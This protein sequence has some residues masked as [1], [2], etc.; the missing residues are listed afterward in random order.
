[1]IAR[2][3][4]CATLAAALLFPGSGAAQGGD[5]RI[6][7]EISAPAAY[8]L[9]DG[10]LGGFGIEIVRAIQKEIGDHTPI[11]VVPWARGYK[12]LTQMPGVALMPTARTA[13]RENL[14][15]W[16]G[17]LMSINWTFYGL[18]GHRFDVKSLDDAR[19]VDGIG[20]YREDV[21]AKFLEEQGFTNLQVVDSQSVNLRKLLRQRIELLV[22]SDVGMRGYMDEDKTLRGKIKPV[23]SFKR[24]DLYLAF[25]KGTDPK[26]L[27]KWSRAYNK[28]LRNGTVEKI[29][30]RW[31]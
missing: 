15:E 8:Y 18:A 12:L 2:F 30:Q 26:I 22:S 19:N 20:V 1:M 3:L 6:Y 21:R 5:F 4:Y 11:E 28:L 24:V 9:T 13:Q 23:L 7:T 27:E 14:F 10:S 17:P 29:Q 31:K 16:V 25:S